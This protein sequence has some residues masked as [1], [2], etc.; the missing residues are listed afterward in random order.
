MRLEEVGQRGL[1]VGHNTGLFVRQAD[2][3]FFGGSIVERKLS[4]A[5]GTFVRDGR[6]ST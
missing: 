1:G 5:A 2:S 6:L 3:L 4:R